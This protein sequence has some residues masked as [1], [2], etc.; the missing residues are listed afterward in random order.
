MYVDN[1][2]NKSNTQHQYIHVEGKMKKKRKGI[3]NIK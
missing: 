2:N 3:H 1:T